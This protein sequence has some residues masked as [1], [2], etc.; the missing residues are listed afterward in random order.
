MSV[1]ALDKAYAAVDE[2]TGFPAVVYPH[3]IPVLADVYTMLP[4]SLAHTATLA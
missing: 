2:L 1:A 3:S 4:V